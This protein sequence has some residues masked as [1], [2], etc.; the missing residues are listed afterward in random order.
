[1]IHVRADLDMMNVIQPPKA[2]LLTYFK[3]LLLTSFYNQHVT[4]KERMKG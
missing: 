4:C 2:L 1:M 3:V